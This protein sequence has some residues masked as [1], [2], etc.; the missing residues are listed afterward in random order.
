MLIGFIPTQKI[1]DNNQDAKTLLLYYYY[2][3]MIYSAVKNYERAM[4]FFEAAVSTP[5]LAMSYIMLESYK[6]YILVSLICEGKLICIPKYSSQVLTR[7]I[8]PLSTPYLALAKAYEDLS[9]DDLT[10][11]V[12]THHEKF[13]QDNNMGLVNLVLASIYKQKIHRLTQTFLTLS[14]ADIA[15]KVRLSGPDEAE[16]YILMMVKGG[17]IFATINKKDGMVVFKD[18][19]EKFNTPATMQL[20]QNEINQVIGMNKHII[21]MEEEI[22]LNP[23]VSYLPT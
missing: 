11:V 17:E 13:A 21:K 23:H 12:S 7:F 4:Y 20:I 8:K 9:S 10:S 14:L 2:G 1:Q 15:Q 5:A 16:R 18:D 3:G 22:K 6:K 19:P